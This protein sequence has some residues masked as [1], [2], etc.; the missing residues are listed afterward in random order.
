MAWRYAWY[1][2]ISF[3][4]STGEQHQRVL[5]RRVAVYLQGIMFY[6]L[7]IFQIQSFY[8]LSTDHLRI[9]LNDRV[10]ATALQQIER[11]PPP[12]LGQ[13]S[14]VDMNQLLQRCLVKMGDLARLLLCI[15]V[16]YNR[17]TG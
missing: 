15:H 5:E 13:S 2:E 11:Y 12:T 17:T 10:C 16:N 3:W 4:R 8:G 9:V 7:L 14:K 6:K 1:Q